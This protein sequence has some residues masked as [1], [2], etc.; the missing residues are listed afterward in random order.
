MGDRRLFTA[1]VL[2]AL[3]AAAAAAA[4]QESA[5]RDARALAMVPGAGRAAGASGRLDCVL[6]PAVFDKAREDLGD[7][8]LIDGKGREIPYA[9]RVRRSRAEPEEIA[10]TPFNQSH[11]PDGPAE[12]SFDL[13]PRPPENRS[14]TVG[15]DGANYRRRAQVQGSDDRADWRTLVDDGP[16][17]SLHVGDQAIDARTLTYAASRPALGL[18][19][20]RLDAGRCGPL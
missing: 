12:S 8:R 13:G 5:E 2:L 9:L 11:D 17:V 7:L 10:A 3:F 6:D 16:L 1:A 4:E 19:R 20:P 14:L 15:P 18:T